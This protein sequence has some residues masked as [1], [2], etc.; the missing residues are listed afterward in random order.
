MKDIGERIK[1]EVEERLGS[2]LAEEELTAMVDA[3]IP[4]VR[5]NLERK[6]E[7]NV[8]KLAEARLDGFFVTYGKRPEFD[9]H[10]KQIADALVQQV[11]DNCNGVRKG[12]DSSW[13]PI[14]RLQAFV[15]DHLYKRLIDKVE[16]T[17]TRL[18]DE[19]RV[20]D[21]ADEVLANI[22]PRAAAAF[23]QTGA[24]SMIKQFGAWVRE[25]H[26][27]NV[28]N[29]QNGHCPSCSTLI[30][31]CPGCG[32]MRRPGDYCCGNSVY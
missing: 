19:P 1:E 9:K 31:T 25:G 5:G 24:A 12:E 26:T 11:I 4:R 18:M 28:H 13:D 30:K 8:H 27:V 2:I 23:A 6:V 17:L 15:N 22:L 16:E 14:R 3:A 29:V 20:Q 7:Q 21:A 32:Q 10:A